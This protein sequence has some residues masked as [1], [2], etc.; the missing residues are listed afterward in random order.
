M[1]RIRMGVIGLGWFGEIHCDAIASVPNLELVA[2]CTRRPDLC[3]PKTS[4]PTIVVM[5]SAKD[6]A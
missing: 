1:D 5:K 2:L 6:G 3:V 4:N